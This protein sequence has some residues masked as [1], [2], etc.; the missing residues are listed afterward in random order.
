[1]AIR[2][3]IWMMLKQTPPRSSLEIRM[4]LKQ[5]PSRSPTK[6]SPSRDPVTTQPPIETAAVPGMMLPS[7]DPAVTPPVEGVISTRP[8]GRDSRAST[9]QYKV[10]MSCHVDHE[11]SP[12]LAGKQTIG[13]VSTRS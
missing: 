10:V 6:R 3:E 7:A 2:L 11:D 4:M 1:M 13:P 5:T 12:K 8:G 9:R